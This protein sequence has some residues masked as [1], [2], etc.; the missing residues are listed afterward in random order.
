MPRD[1][2]LIAQI[3]SI[4]KSLTPGQKP[5]ST[6]SAPAGRNKGH[7]DR[8]WALVLACQKERF[9]QADANELNVA[10]RVIG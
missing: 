9:A 1:R 7:A 3:H 10:V 6:P 8:F 2:E 4:K 5:A